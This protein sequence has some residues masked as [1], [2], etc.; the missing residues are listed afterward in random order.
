M[1][2]S[3]YDLAIG[4]PMR[5]IKLLQPADRPK[6]VTT[7]RKSKATAAKRRRATR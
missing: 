2:S 4:P 1:R 5:K 3:N 7:P 6:A